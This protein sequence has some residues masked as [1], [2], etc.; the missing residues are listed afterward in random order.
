MPMNHISQ[1]IAETRDPTAAPPLLPLLHT[2]DAFQF[3]SILENDFTLTPRMDAGLGK[4]LV[5]FFYGKPAY[6]AAS[7]SYSSLSSAAPVFMLIDFAA[8]PSVHRVFLLDSGAFLNGKFSSYF[9]KHLS[10][11]ALEVSLARGRGKAQAQQSAIAAV[12]AFYGSNR[13]YYN[14]EPR[15]DLNPDALHFEVESFLNLASAKEA[16]EFDDR[17]SVIEVSTSA[18]VKIEPR[19]LHALILPDELLDASPRFMKHLT[20]YKST[21]MIGYS[22][23]RSSPSYFAALAVEKVGDYLVSQKL[24]ENSR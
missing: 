5:F 18:S 14:S 9:P 22:I 17:G 10:I 24:L 12:Q 21:K 15:K 8:L 11:E 20:A 2:T 23:F 1:F 7:P 19:H 4:S 6:R 13:N 3:R 16:T